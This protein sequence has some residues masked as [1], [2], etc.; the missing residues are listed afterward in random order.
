MSVIRI[1]AAVVLDD[2]GRLLVVRKRGTTVFIQPGGKVEPG[3]TPAEALVREVR[4][5]LGAGVL[6]VR[7]IGHREAPAANEPGHTVEAD[8]FLVELD[9]PPRVCAEIDELAWVDPHAPGD[10]ELAPLTVGAV[11]DWV[12]AQAN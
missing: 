3:E 8:L 7:E 11:L 2:D 1:V 5:E 4:E 10:V 6:T 9:A 12:R